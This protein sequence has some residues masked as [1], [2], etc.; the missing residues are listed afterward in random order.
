MPQN[1]RRQLSS[2]LRRLVAQEKLE[3][4]SGLMF[5]A[6]PHLRQYSLYKEVIDEHNK[7]AELAS[8][9]LFFLLPLVIYC[10]L[11]TASYGLIPCSFPCKIKLLLYM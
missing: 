7:I 8:L 4:V 3:K 9:V 10:Q 5:L 1:F 6:M 11:H 2:R